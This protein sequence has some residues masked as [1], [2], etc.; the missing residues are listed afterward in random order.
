MIGGP[1]DK[2][3]RKLYENGRQWEKWRT[4][5][6]GSHRIS[7]N[8]GVGDLGGMKCGWTKGW[9]CPGEGNLGRR[10]GVSGIWGVGY[11]WEESQGEVAETRLVEKA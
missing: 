4:H 6:N 3:G 7:V 8:C 2:Q 11:V 5:S 10:K 1:T 9:A